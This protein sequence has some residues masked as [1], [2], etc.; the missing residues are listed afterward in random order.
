[1]SFRVPSKRRRLSSF[2]ASRSSNV[3]GG[4][5]SSAAGS[6]PTLRAQTK[7]YALQPAVRR[8]SLHDPSARESSVLSS[9]RSAVQ[10]PGPNPAGDEQVDPGTSPERDVDIYEREDDDS[11]NE[12]IMAVDLRDR[13]TVGCAYYV[14][15]EQKLYMMEDIR[16]AGIA[17]IETCM[18]PFL[19]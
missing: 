18:T 5:Q 7:K 2:A 13:G 15:R 14:A 12:V 9:S 4:G 3:H 10:H 17:V 1:M 16:F 19:T 8:V 6:S 11:M